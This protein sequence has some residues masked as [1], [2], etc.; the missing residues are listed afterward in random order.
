M[1]QCVSVGNL[2]DESGIEKKHHKKAN[3]P[4]GE[5][6]FTPRRSPRG[7]V[8]NRQFK[9]MEVEYKPGKRQGTNRLTLN[10]L[11]L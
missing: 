2:T 9:D 3:I 10:F 11:S 6:L 5:S 7:I 4:D 8:P 1:L